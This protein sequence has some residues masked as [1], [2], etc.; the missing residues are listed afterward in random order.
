MSTGWDEGA[1]RF[2]DACEQQEGDR[3]SS[4][5]SAR[6]SAR[7]DVG[8]TW[9]GPHEP[10]TRTPAL[11]PDLR[12]DLELATALREA[13]RSVPGPDPDASARMRASLMAAI[14]GDTQESAATSRVLGD[15]SGSA[16]GRGAGR[17]GH[18]ARATRTSGPGRRSGEH[19]DRRSR[20]GDARPARGVEGRRRGRSGRIL[21]NAVTATC[22]VMLLGALTVVLGRGALPGEM[23]YGVKR[24]SESVEMALTGGQEAKARKHLDFAGLRLE[25]VS[26]LVERGSATAAGPRPAAAGLDPADAAL[27]G[28]NLRAFDEQARA[29][30]R[31]MLP[32]SGR[33]N[34]PDP[35]ELAS[36]AREQTARLDT[37]SPSLNGDDRAAAASSKS[38]MDRMSTRASALDERGACD[39]V[40][41]G[42][43]ELGPLPSSARC[44]AIDKP[45]AAPER[46]TTT[47]S[48]SSTTSTTTTTT[49][50]D[51]S[52]S[53]E[54]SSTTSEKTSEEPTTEETT[55]SPVRVPMPVP[56]LP[57]VDVP[58]LL[59][60]LP[61]L[62]LG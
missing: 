42:E 59:P 47:S 1:E 18:T 32:L 17:A 51:S 27:V 40:S 5:G 50:E 55:R 37:L 29:G 44:P 33:A 16:G 34:G 46:P 56:L 22:V 30:S 54:K 53:T 23:L 15:V 38:L 60:G 62:S 31:M 11:D 20:P 8:H 2:A 25:E 57:Q 41:T 14:G 7:G 9:A 19:T 12:Q 48:S 24:S 13:S 36:W 61:G 58:P 26:G 35:E 39:E 3:R 28:D 43:D 52:S 45:V 6:R 21:V 10:T 49:T 4:E